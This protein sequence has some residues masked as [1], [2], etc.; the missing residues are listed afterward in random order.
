MSRKMSRKLIIVCVL[1]FVLTASAKVIRH[2]PED[3]II[4]WRKTVAEGQ[5]LSH[6]ILACDPNGQFLEGNYLVIT[7]ENMPEGMVLSAAYPICMEGACEPPDPL[8]DPN[9]IVYGADLEWTPTHIQAGTYLVLI[10]CED[11]MGNEDNKW[12]EIIVIEED[13]EPPFLAG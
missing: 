6:T 8:C 12:F 7:S 10:H 1:V 5:T 11:K 13:V 4:Q 3:G 2:S 9:C